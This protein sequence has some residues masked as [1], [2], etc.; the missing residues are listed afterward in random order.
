MRLLATG[1]NGQ[2]V[3]ALIERGAVSGVDIIAM[4]RPELDL[5][6]PQE[7][8]FHIAQAKPHVIVSAAAY[9][10]V[11]KAEGEQDAAEAVN[12]HGPAALARLA[13]ELH[14]PIIQLSTDYVFDGKKPSPYVE[15]DPTNP[16]GT[17]GRTK[18]A[19]EIAVA[20]ATKNHAILRTAWVYSPFGE[21][22]LKTMLRLAS[23]R[24]ELRVVDDQRGNPTSALDI[25]D[26]VIKIAAN[27]IARPDDAALRGTFHITGM[28]DAS[29][30]DFASEIFA[31]S[32]NLGGPKASV[33]PIST[34]DYPTPARRPVNS[35]LDSSKLR[36]AHGITMPDWRC[37]THSTISRLLA[38]A[39]NIIRD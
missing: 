18:L 26:A 19:G 6:N 4:G 10:A 24:P 37:S 16:L 31:H 12:A 33:T 29:W 1:K 38:G 9:T 5:A 7:G 27:L 20:A 17:Y 36:S 32:A 3:T 28:G 34:E 25:A 21:N 30:A 39:E 2:V 23:T 35:R 22:F 11:D 14:I 15:S 13:A 8:L